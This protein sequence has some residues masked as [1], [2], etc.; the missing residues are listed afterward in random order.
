M[1][2][3]FKTLLFGI[4][5]LFVVSTGVGL[6]YWAFSVS[7][8]RDIN[9]GVDVDNIYENYNVGKP[10]QIPQFDM[11]VFPSSHYLAQYKSNQNPEDLYGYMDVKL[12]L[13]EN[14]NPKVEEKYVPGKKFPNNTDVTQMA[15]EYCKDIDNNHIYDNSKGEISYIKIKQNDFQYEGLYKNVT[16]NL[17][18]KGTNFN[19]WGIYSTANENLDN[20]SDLNDLECNITYNGVNYTNLKDVPSETFSEEA[21]PYYQTLNVDDRLGYWYEKNVE[22][23][24]F[25]P[26]KISFSGSIT[27]D[28][29]S[30]LVHNPRTDISDANGWHNFKFSN[31]VYCKDPNDKTYDIP[32]DAFS[33]Y[34]KKNVFNVLNDL[35]TMANKE[36]GKYVLR[37]FPTFSNGKDY[38]SKTGEDVGRESPLSTKSDIELGKGYRDGIKIDL[39]TRNKNTG[40]I[41]Y[42]S[43]YFTFPGGN[44][45]TFLSNAGVKYNYSVVNNFN[46]NT[47]VEDITYVD[48]SSSL[49][50]YVNDSNIFVNRYKIDYSDWSNLK[51]EQ[52]FNNIKNQNIFNTGDKNIYC[53]STKELYKTEQEAVDAINN[54][55]KEFEHVNL[56]TGLVTYIGNKNDFASRSFVPVT[57]NETTNQKIISTVSSQESDN[58]DSFAGSKNHWYHAYA[59]FFERILDFKV[60]TDVPANNVSV[61]KSTTHPELDAYEEIIDGGIKQ[62]Y[63]DNYTRSR[64]LVY[65]NRHYYKG[66]RN[67]VNF[68]PDK[69]SQGN[70]ILENDT[71][72]FIYKIDLLDLNNISH[73]FFGIR[74][75]KEDLGFDIHY[76][77]DPLGKNISQNRYL[78]ET[79]ATLKSGDSPEIKYDSS[80]F[81]NA[82]MYLENIM[83]R[84]KKGDELEGFKVKELPEGQGKPNGL[85]SIILV[86]APKENIPFN[87]DVYVYKSTNLFVKIF[88]E[89][90]S[91]YGPE[92]GDREG[93]INHYDG[94]YYQ[95]DYDTGM[96]LKDFHE[97]KNN[98]TGQVSTL[99]EL[100]KEIC[101]KRENYI[102]SNTD[103]NYK[104]GYKDS[105]SIYYLIDSVTKV[106][107]SKI[108]MKT[109][110]AKVSTDSILM[111]TENHVLYV[112]SHDAYVVDES[113]PLNPKK[114]FN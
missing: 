106:I 3:R 10:N 73:L 110:E 72:R 18:E 57:L 6:S 84:N 32:R 101:T 93:F 41:S 97:Y 62:H 17:F 15:L 107:A 80:L 42:S 35:T 82:S 33:N 5:G 47:N 26:I 67:G 56:E 71:Y 70:P 27:P 79:L 91:L 19:D 46:I 85:Y 74:L 54:L 40:D 14:G 89:K 59:F 49:I 11:F 64:N 9:S 113:N 114:Y 48:F 4:C 61:G 92:G 66:E 23:G 39:K 108:D 45:Q 55:I 20:K 94:Q 83:F 88:D 103:P 60:I 22:D 68:I 98:K 7:A 69:D 90:P 30:T 34:D 76:N 77:L 12:A 44:E 102:V 100:F 109:G 112:L 86:Y 95:K 58:H 37:L 16:N 75:A 87:F 65:E 111:V 25:L 8:N 52:S 21:K 96:Y 63:I 13:D 51:K 81:V 29:F 24:R 99:T 2:R 43:R 36:S 1:F 38:P 104:K 78:Y 31:W 50:S 105:N 53:F 28:A